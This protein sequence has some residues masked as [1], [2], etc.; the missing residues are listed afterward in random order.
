[1]TGDQTLPLCPGSDKL[2]QGFI[3]CICSFG[4]PMECGGYCQ[5]GDVDQML[6]EACLSEKCIDEYEACAADI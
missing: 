6:C 4:C 3:D 5:G 1:M 2:F